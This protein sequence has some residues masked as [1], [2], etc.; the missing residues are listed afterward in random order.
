M[1]YNRDLELEEYDHDEA[2]LV[3]AQAAQDSGH[4][5][6]LGKIVGDKM[7]LAK[8]QRA[9][10]HSLAPHIAK[11]IN[12]FAVANGYAPNALR[13][14]VKRYCLVGNK[15]GTRTVAADVKWAGGFPG[16]AEA[17]V[18]H[19]DLRVAR[20]YYWSGNKL[21]VANM[22]VLDNGNTLRLYN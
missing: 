3:A 1:T 17:I 4:V 2:T 14:P 18:T 9:S 21:L 22:D 12:E 10:A 11:A 7:R 19:A 15:Y 8:Y 13:V 16:W 5:L 20:E 6:A